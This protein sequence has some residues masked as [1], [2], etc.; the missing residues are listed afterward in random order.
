MITI[1][2]YLL[3]VDFYL[4]NVDLLSGEKSYWYGYL[5][6]CTGDAQGPGGGTILEMG[7]GTAKDCVW[8]TI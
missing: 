1:I 3:D 5:Y 2:F 8:S 4:P 6:L 7:E